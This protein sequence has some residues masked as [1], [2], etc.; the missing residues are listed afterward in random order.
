MEDT[1]FYITTVYKLSGQSITEELVNQLSEFYGKN[2]INTQTA[3]ATLESLKPSNLP[4]VE[5]S[6]RLNDATVVIPNVRSSA[7]PR[8]RARSVD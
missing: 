5:I 4:S 3:L 2:H 6:R 1:V 7:I 8:V